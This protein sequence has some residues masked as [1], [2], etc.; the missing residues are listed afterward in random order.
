[1][2]PLAMIDGNGEMI[3]GPTFSLLGLGWDALYG[4]CVR[5]AER[6]RVWEIALG[7]LP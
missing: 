3:F 4:L 2:W 1:M 6:E 7:I 5:I